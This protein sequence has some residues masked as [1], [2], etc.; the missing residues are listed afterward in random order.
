MFLRRTETQSKSKPSK[1]WTFTAHCIV[2]IL[3]RPFLDWLLDRKLHWLTFYSELPVP[4]PNLLLKAQH[5]TWICRAIHDIAGKPEGLHWFSN[6]KTTFNA[7]PEKQMPT[8]LRVNH[9]Q[10]ASTL[11]IK[12][13]VLIYLYNVPTSHGIRNFPDTFKTKPP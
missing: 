5:P 6:N 4:S 11:G 12:V 10:K 2:L 9:V 13:R 3:L 7:V 8:G 1:T